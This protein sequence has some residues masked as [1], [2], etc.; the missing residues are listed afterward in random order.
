MIALHQLRATLS[1]LSLAPVLR[2]EGLRILQADGF[3]V[4]L[5]IFWDGYGSRPRVA[6]IARQSGRA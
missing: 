5:F 4:G 3:S 2:G 1:G 6:P